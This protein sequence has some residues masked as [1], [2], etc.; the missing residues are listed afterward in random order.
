MYACMH[1]GLLEIFLPNIAVIY[2]IDEIVLYIIL[3]FF[4]EYEYGK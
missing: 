2:I 3:V 1:L 4:P